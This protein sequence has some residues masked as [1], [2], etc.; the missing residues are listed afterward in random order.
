MSFLYDCLNN[1][2]FSLV[3]FIVK[4]QYIMHRAYK[5]CVNQPFMLLVR[6]LVNSGLLTVKFWGTHELYT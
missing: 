5:I 2:Y 4:M 1:I 3:Y 6:I